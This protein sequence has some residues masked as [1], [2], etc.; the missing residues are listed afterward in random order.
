[1]TFISNFARWEGDPKV[2]RSGPSSLGGSDRMARALGW[3]S[4]GLGMT[5]LL[6]TQNITRALGME[7]RESLL[8]FYGAR[9]IASGILTL[10]TEQQLGL[11]SR[12][13][14]DGIDIATLL[15]AMRRDNPKRDN[16]GL[17]LATVLGVTLLDLIGAEAVKA[18]H[19][20][21]I[22]R[23]RS[24]GDRSGFPGG[25]KAA[26]GAARGFGDSASSGSTRIGKPGAS[27]STNDGLIPP[28][29]S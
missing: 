23:R 3:L 25:V 27:A 7:G 5:E 20:R 14:G 29:R 21:D 15:T 16:V 19:R 9:E 6:A 11:W 22:G 24:Y 8:R 12:V 1:M 2:L 4:I 28:P 17:A 18:R 26:R 13:A 10:S